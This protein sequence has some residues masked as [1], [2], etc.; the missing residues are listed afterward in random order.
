[1][2]MTYEGGA[3]VIRDSPALDLAN[4]YFAVRGKPREGLSTPAD[5]AAW[6]LEVAPQ[7]DG[8]ELPAEELAEVREGDLALFLE[9]RSA[10]RTL[11]SDLTKGLP[12]AEGPV[13]VLNRAA[14]VAPASPVLTLTP[15]GAL[16]KSTRAR[17]TAPRAA[18]S[19]LARDA[20]DLFS[21]ERL[22]QLRD[23]QAPG[24]FLFFL[25]DHPRREW[26]TPAC[27]MRVRASRAYYKRTHTE[28]VSPG[29]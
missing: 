22:D 6:V 5:V 4:T 27:G 3:P 26:C 7:L 24:C 19:A 8:I 2:P 23:C 16:S 20:A 29:S 10:V 21:G 14:A 15:Q 13:A 28:E 18:L 25:K 17:S 1:M 11:A 9:L 12:P